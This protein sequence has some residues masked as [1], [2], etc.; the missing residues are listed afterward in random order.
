MKRTL[1]DM[2]KYC[3]VLQKSPLFHG[4]SEEDL[5]HSLT[6]WGG[7]VKT[8]GRHEIIYPEGARVSQIGVILEGFVDTI[9]EDYWG[10]RTLLRRFQEGQ[11]FADS[12]IVAKEQAM[13]FTA[14]SASDTVVLMLS[15]QKMLEPC[16]RI[17]DMHKRLV[18]NLLTIT[19]KNNIMLLRKI[20]LLTKRTVREKLMGFLS[21]EARKAGSNQFRLLLNRQELADYLAMDRSTLSSELSK[22]H[23]EG[24]LTR[25]KNM[26]TI[27]REEELEGNAE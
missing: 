19:A 5:Q 6:C 1:L 16:E 14:V 24:I 23:R 8:Y 11:L 18:D 25:D 26:I 2:D 20:T 27:H 22:M 12:F 15:Y 17:C 3:A 4:F 13:P 9:L 10:N 21:S 7:S